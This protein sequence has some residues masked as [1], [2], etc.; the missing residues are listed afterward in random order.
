MFEVNKSMTQPG[1]TITQ[2]YVTIASAD[3]EIA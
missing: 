1:V 2:Q 3:E